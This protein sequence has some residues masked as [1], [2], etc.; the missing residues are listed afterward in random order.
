LESDLF[1]KGTRPA[2][3]VGNSVSRVGGSAQAK[4]MKKNAGP[5]KL[6]LA[7]FRELESFAQFSSDLDPDTKKTIER[8]RRLAEVLKQPQYSPVSMPQQ[9]AILYAANKGYLDKVDL[10]KVGAWEEGLQEFM[11]SSKSDVLAMLEKG[12]GESEEEALKGAIEEFVKTQK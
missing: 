10:E 2:I 6:Q 1:Y 7:Q 11:V 3:N 8:G 4:A 12:W 5:L 9:V